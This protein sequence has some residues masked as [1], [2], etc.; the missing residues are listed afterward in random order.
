MIEWI[1]G[2]WHFDDI[3][4]YA[5]DGMEVLFPDGTW[6]PVRIESEFCGQRLYA[7]FEFHG[8]ELRILVMD[9]NRVPAPLANLR[10]PMRSIPQCQPRPQHV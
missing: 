4:I 6:L 2:R 9:L 3:P 10:W 5:G 7:H 8:K 1:D